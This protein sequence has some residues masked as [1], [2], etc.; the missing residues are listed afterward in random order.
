MW[1]AGL[2]S[3]GLPQRPDVAVDHDLSL[4]PWVKAADVAA[5][6]MLYISDVKDDHAPFYCTAHGVSH[7]I[8]LS[9]SHIPPVFATVCYADSGP[10]AVRE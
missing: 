2:V 6:G 3:L 7:E 1:L 5:K 9:N 8:R 4:S 10:S